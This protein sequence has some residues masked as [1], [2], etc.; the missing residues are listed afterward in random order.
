M[1]CTYNPNDRTLICE[2]I[3]L[4]TNPQ[5]LNDKIIE[6]FPSNCVNAQ[7]RT[8]C[9]KVQPSATFWKLQAN[10]V[11]QCHNKNH[12]YKSARCANAKRPDRGID[13]LDSSFRKDCE[14]KTEQ[15]YTN[16]VCALDPTDGIFSRFG[17]T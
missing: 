12:A 8:A 11:C 14:I 3:D 6:N 4:T 5:I 2:N 1:S 7:C 13:D 9:L 10:N 16:V 15:G 17:F